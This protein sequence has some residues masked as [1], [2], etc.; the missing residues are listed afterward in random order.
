MSV[1]ALAALIV[2]LI[3]GA[4]GVSPMSAKI[5]AIVVISCMSVLAGL[6]VFA[7]FVFH[8][9]GRLVYRIGYYILHVGLVLLIAGMI[10][11]ELATVTN[12]RVAEDENG[13]TV[14]A[15]GDYYA[16][17]QNVNSIKV[18]KKQFVRYGEFFSL[19]SVVYEKYEDGTPKY[20]EAVVSVKDVNSGLI[21]EEKTL[22]VNH[23]QYI[24]GY[25]IYLMSVM[26][27]C[28]G[29]V[30][31]I[32]YNPGEFIVIIGIAALICGTFAACFSGFAQRK[33]K[34]QK[35]GKRR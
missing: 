17:G 10:V 25:K 34:P 15:H 18:G 2:T 1:I 3:V 5:G 20:F 33:A 22:T 35:E 14:T 23:P 31:L 16:V 30:L 9:G 28:K 32:K 19:D 4:T 11:T 12:E 21:R 6:T 26:P 7:L 8:I 29:A 13:A 27:T 24:D